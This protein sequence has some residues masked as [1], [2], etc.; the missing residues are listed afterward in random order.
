MTDLQ[1]PTSHDYLFGEAC[2]GGGCCGGVCWRLIGKFG[3]ILVGVTVRWNGVLDKPLCGKATLL[4]PASI[5]KIS[6][7]NLL[8]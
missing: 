3:V 4:K 2:C 6:L 7:I 5:E 1:Y 8:F